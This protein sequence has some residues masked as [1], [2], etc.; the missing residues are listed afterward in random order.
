VVGPGS[1]ALNPPT[2][3]YA[4][5]TSVTV[6]ALP[7]PGSAFVGWSGDLTGS[8][9]PATLIVDGNESVV[10]SFAALYDVGVNV[11]GPGSVVRQARF[12]SAGSGGSSW[13]IGPELAAALPLLAWL[14]GRRRRAVGPSPR[15]RN[16]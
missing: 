7:E 8:T 12:T 2:G 1:I 14:H 10:A 5:G 4:L 11:T 9:N 13:G 3:P 15:A 6:T 16:P